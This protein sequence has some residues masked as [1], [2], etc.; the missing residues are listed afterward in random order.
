MAD[1][2]KKTVS[3]MNINDVDSSTL[4]LQKEQVGFHPY[5]PTE[6][7]KK[8]F[9]KVISFDD[10]DQ[11]FLR[12]TIQASCTHDCLTGK[13]DDAEKVQ[14]KAGEFFNVSDYFGLPLGKYLGHE[15]LVTCKRSKELKNN[16]SVWIWDVEVTPE[17]ARLVKASQEAALNAKSPQVKQVEA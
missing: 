13:K 12:W 7:G 14:V 8:F 10:K 4:G 1:K 11:D 2:A 5:W 3:E 17:V 6:E 16:K 9:G 15:V